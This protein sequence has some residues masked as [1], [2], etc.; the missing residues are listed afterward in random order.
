MRNKINYLKKFL[1]SKI[2][3]ALVYGFKLQFVINDKINNIPFKFTGT[4][5]GDYEVFYILIVGFTGKLVNNKEYINNYYHNFM[6]KRL[7]NN[8]TF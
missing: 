7:I 2:N 8:Y 5:I 3:L 1:K 6:V 4:K